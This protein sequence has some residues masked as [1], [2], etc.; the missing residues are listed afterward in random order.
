MKCKQ[1]ANDRYCTNKEN[2]PKDCEWFEEYEESARFKAYD[3]MISPISRTPERI[4]L[5]HALGL[6]RRRTCGSRGCYLQV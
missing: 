4:P 1:C 5:V 6:I 3:Q 2:P